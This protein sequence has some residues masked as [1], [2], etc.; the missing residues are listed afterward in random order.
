MLRRY[1]PNR[2]L[3]V[4]GTEKTVNGNSVTVEY[5]P[6]GGYLM[7]VNRKEYQFYR[8]LWRDEDGRYY[9]RG[10]QARLRRIFAAYEAAK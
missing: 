6:G 4:T 1:L 5:L 7:R 8:G 9:S 2:R 10:T 3:N